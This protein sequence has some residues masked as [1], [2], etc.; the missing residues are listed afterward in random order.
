MHTAKSHMLDG[1][2]D[3]R[4]CCDMTRK[5]AWNRHQFIV[6][7]NRTRRWP[8]S[9]KSELIQLNDRKSAYRKQDHRSEVTHVEAACTYP[10][11]KTYLVRSHPH[12]I[13]PMISFPRLI[14][15][16]EHSKPEPRIFKA[17]DNNLGRNTL[18]G[19]ILICNSWWPDPLSGY[20]SVI[21]PAASDMSR[22]L[23]GKYKGFSYVTMKVLPES[24]ISS[25][26]EI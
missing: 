11:A 19:E 17:S 24:Q 16:R 9:V 18:W 13:L 1:S 15:E 6:H 8:L 25:T 10:T 23:G 2:L 7:P 14:S 4:Q 12:N 26:Y 3:M 20:K 21:L 22:R 5:C